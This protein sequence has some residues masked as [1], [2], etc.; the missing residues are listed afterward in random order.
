MGIVVVL[1]H[2]EVRLWV[3]WGKAGKMDSDVVVKLKVEVVR[4]KCGVG[5]GHQMKVMMIVMLR[6][7]D[8]GASRREGQP[9]V[10]DDHGGV[11][12]RG[13]GWV[14]E[15]VDVRSAAV[16]LPCVG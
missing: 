7:F 8:G 5:L 14:Q 16:R 12:V 1:W 9:R 6:A 3:E 2:V 11:L 15:L 13:Q 4:I 10:G